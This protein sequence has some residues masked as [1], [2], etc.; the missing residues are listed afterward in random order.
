VAERRTSFQG[1]QVDLLPFL[2]AH[3]D[4]FVLKPND[5]YGGKG[6]LLGWE[7]GQSEWEAALK[8][9]LTEPYIVQQR[10]RIPSEPYPSLVEGRVQIYDRLIDT[11][12]YIWYGDYVSGCLTR[13]ST[14]ELLNVTAGGG[15]VVPTFVVE[16]R[17]NEERS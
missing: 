7:T 6:I 4:E 9:A 2:S 13:L 3:K 15:S 17:S 12:P 5:E 10:V 1:Q 14:V 8:S 16:L 11:N